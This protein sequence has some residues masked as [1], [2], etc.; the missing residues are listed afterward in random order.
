V[1]FA[2]KILLAFMHDSTWASIIGGGDIGVDIDD[3]ITEWRIRVARH[4][5]QAAVYNKEASD[6]GRQRQGFSKKGLQGTRRGYT[7]T[8]IGLG[9]SH[10]GLP[11]QAG[12]KSPPSLHRRP[13]PA[14]R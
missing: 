5:R 13:G 11:R 4:I 7:Y 9:A 8:T 3:Y 14:T 12:P 10:I 1:V 6:V 2:P